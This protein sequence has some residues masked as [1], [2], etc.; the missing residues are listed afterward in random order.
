[1]I[2][3]LLAPGD[4]VEV[5]KIRKQNEKD[6]I[7][8]YYSKIYD[9]IDEDDIIK[10]AMPVIG[11]KMVLLGLKM[12]YEIYILSE[13]GIYLAQGTLIDR[14]KENNLFVAV[15]QLN[16][17]LEKIQRRQFYRL[18][19]NIEVKY[20]LLSVKDAETLMEV[21]SAEE[22]NKIIDAKEYI[23]GI[24]ID[25]S[26]GGLRFTSDKEH[27]RGEFVIIEFPV[28]AQGKKVNLS[29]LSEIILTEKVPNRV[30][31]YDHRISYTNISNKDRE[32]LIKYIFEE[33]RRYRKNEK[34]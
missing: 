26:G 21:T 23:N 24:T 25:I 3:N 19:T 17:K 2:S 32:V 11:T 8:T 29:I 34:G 14:Y 12:N 22:Y 9:I 4:K 6:K 16:T 31:I 10:I 30:G 15:I 33:E 27:K 7:K 13:S 20:K 1:M 28:I 18:E 5:T